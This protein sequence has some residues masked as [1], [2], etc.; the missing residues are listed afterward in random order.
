MKST[1]CFLFVFMCQVLQFLH[2]FPCSVESASLPN[3]SFSWMD[4][5]VN[6]G[7]NPFRPAACVGWRGKRMVISRRRK[8][9]EGSSADIQIADRGFFYHSTNVLGA[10]LTL[11]N[12]F[13]IFYHLAIPAVVVE[14]FHSAPLKMFHERQKT[15]FSHRCTQVLRTYWQQLA[16]F[17]PSLHFCVNHKTLVSTSMLW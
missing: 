6:N 7:A 15:H 10:S 9:K 14:P 2:S 5:L 3:I 4:V 17:R 8:L 12:G 1:I 13:G 11:G 16:R